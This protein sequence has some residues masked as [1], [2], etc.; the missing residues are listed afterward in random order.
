MLLEPKRARQPAGTE[1]FERPLHSDVSQSKLS[2]SLSLCSLS[3]SA[4]F[5]RSRLSA[6]EEQGWMKKRIELSLT[7]VS[8]N[9]TFT[10]VLPGY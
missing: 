1:E 9:S 8:K 5:S 10:R 3:L 6:E 4:L 7:R 2:L